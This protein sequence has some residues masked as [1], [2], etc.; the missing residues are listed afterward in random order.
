LSYLHN[1]THVPSKRKSPAIFAYEQLGSNFAARLQ[2]WI[3]QGLLALDRY[4]CGIGALVDRVVSDPDYLENL[5]G[6]ATAAWIDMDRNAAPNGSLMRT[7]PIG[8]IGVGLSELKTWNLVIN[9]GSMTHVDLRCTVSCCIQV[10]LI[11]GLLRGE[12]VN[13]TDLNKCIERSYWFV[14][15]NEVRSRYK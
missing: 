6:V 9:V 1:Y 13:E 11:R 4:A 7:H 8:I 12:I 15:G 2:I 14:R 5:A 10:A 3:E